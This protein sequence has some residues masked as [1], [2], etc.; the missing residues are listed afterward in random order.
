MKT[1]LCKIC[2]LTNSLCNNCQAKLDRGEITRLDAEV[3]SF[4][5]R[6]TKSRKEMED[7]E[8]LY[9]T[10]VDDH[11]VPFFAEGDLPKILSNGRD[12]LEAMEKK[13][14]TNVLA[15]EH[16]SNLRRFIEGLFHPLP[17]AAVNV[18]WLPDGSQEARVVLEKRLSGFDR[19]RADLASKIAQKTRDVALEVEG[20]R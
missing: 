11:L 16:H 8:F 19:Q 18:I 2:K 5:G 3:A 17:V 15:V 20:T 13:F 7:V 10:Y 14:R 9:A 12:I 6:E 1:P 4:L